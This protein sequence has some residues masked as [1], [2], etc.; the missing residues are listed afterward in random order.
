MYGGLILGKITM[1]GVER[2]WL[3]SASHCQSH[4]V[5]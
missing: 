1:V 2:R 4:M 3:I 5:T